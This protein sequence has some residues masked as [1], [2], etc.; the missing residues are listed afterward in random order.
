M[1][2]PK[3]NR[4]PV[5]AMQTAATGRQHQGCRQGPHQYVRTAKAARHR[6]LVICLVAVTMIA[7]A[8]GGRPSTASKV[9]SSTLTSSLSA[10]SFTYD[11]SAMKM[12][13][14]VVS[15]GHGKVAVLL[16]A[17]TSAAR[18]VEFDTPDFTKAMQVAG[19]TAPEYVVQTPGSTTTQWPTRRP[20]CS[21]VP[22]C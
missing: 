13:R 6:A 20:T 9:K 15:Q 18:Y 22:P 10:S 7:T 11:F 19:V 2:A 5:P 1:V 21:T 16:P 4:Y 3:G 8:C 14:K 12:L 17:I